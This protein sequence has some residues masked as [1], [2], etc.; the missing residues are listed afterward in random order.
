MVFTIF[1]FILSRKSQIKFLLAPMKSLITVI[2]ENPYS[3]SLQML[4]CGDLDHENAYRSPPEV[5]N[6]ILEAA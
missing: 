6:I 2:C 4:N 3:N 5:R 1:S